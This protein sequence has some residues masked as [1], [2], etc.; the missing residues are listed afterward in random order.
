MEL[1]QLKNDWMNN[2]LVS[3]FPCTIVQP[4][5]LYISGEVWQDKEHPQLLSTPRC[6]SLEWNWCEKVFLCLWLFWIFQSPQKW[7]LN[8]K[9]IVNISILQQRRTSSCWASLFDELHVKRICQSYRCQPWLKRYYEYH[10]ISET[11]KESKA[12]TKR[13]PR[14][15]SYKGGH[16]V[17]K[18]SLLVGLNEGEKPESTP[19]RATSVVIW[20]VGPVEG[21][22]N[23]QD[24]NLELIKE[25]TS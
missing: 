19:V 17:S 23:R 4:W 8:P 18:H 9:Y 2:N 22:L 15:T 11:N 5:S 1:G 6:Q 14:P 10:D 20:A 13:K 24:H 21:N 3:T 12:N 16:N 25:H 7:G